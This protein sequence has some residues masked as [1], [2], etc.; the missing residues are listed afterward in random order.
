MS[1]QPETQPD[2]GQSSLRTKAPSP[3]SDWRG[4]GKALKLSSRN[5]Q[6]WFKRIFMSTLF[7]FY[8]KHPGL[9]LKNEIQ[10][11]ISLGGE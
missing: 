7:A 10:S 5:M 1:L 6:S 3:T 9:K 2:F 8:L 11:S 4:G